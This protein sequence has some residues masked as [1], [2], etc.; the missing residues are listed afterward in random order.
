[1]AG[2]LSAC[3]NCLV[4]ICG[5][6]TVQAIAQTT[7]TVGTASS[8]SSLSGPTTST[9]STVRTERHTAIYSLAELNTAGLTGGS[10]LFGIAWDKTGVGT[11]SNLTI[12]VWLNHVSSAT[13]AANPSF[14]TETSAA[15]MV[16]ENA[17][18]TISATTGFIPFIFNTNFFTWNGADN[19]QV[20]TEIVKIAAY[21]NTSFSWRT[22][23]T[24]TNTAANNSGA[25][26]VDA[27]SRTG[28]RPQV[29]FDVATPGNDAALIGMP[30][31]VAA[32]PGTQQVEVILKNTGSAVLNTAA[33]TYTINGTPTTYNWAGNL[34]TGQ[35]EN[36]VLGSPNFAIGNYTIVATITSAN[37]G[38]DQSAGNNQV[39]KNVTI[40]NALTG[41]YTINKTQPTA[42]T[43]FNSFT[44]FAANLT[45]CGVVGDVVA[46]VVPGTGPYREQVIFKNIAG[47]GPASGLTIKGNGEV[48]TSDTAINQTGSNPARHIIRL[49]DM[50][51]FTIDSLKINMFTGST[52]FMGVHVFN[53]GSYITVK[54][55]T[56]DMGTA[57]STLLGALAATGSESSLLTGGNYTNI[58]FVNN[59]TVG[60]GYGAVM[61]G[62]AATPVA[63]SAITGNTFNGTSSNGIYVHTTNDL[64]IKNNTLN[65]TSAN[66][67]QLASTANVRSLVDG[68]IISGT[69]ATT[70]GTLSAIV[71]GGS[72]T[73]TNANRVVNNVIWKMNAPLGSVIGITGSGTGQYFFNTIILDDASATGARAI[74]FSEGGAT[75][76]A[77]VRSNIFYITRPAS[78]YNAA[79]GLTSTSVVT[80]AVLSSHNVFFTNGST[81][82]VAVRQGLT[83][84]NPPTNIYTDLP[85]WQTA[86]TQETG[87]FQTD[88]AF[89]PGT[90]KPTSGTIN[91]QG[92]SGAGILNDI[93][94]AMRTATPD[95]GA[96]EFTPAGNDAALTAF[97]Q[98]ALPH[99]AP[100]LAVQFELTNSGSSILTSATIN[101]TVNG[102]PQPVF[103]WTG[104]IAP[105]ASTNVTL[106]S[107]AIA[108]ATLYTF[109][110]LVTLPNGQPDANPA[111][112]SFTFNGFRAGFSGN[113]TIDGGNPASGTNYQS[114]QAIAAD[115][116][117]YGV[118]GPVNI[119][120]LNG[121]YTQQVVFT[122]IPGTSAT[123]AIYINGKGQELSFN[124]TSSAADHILKLSNVHYIQIDSLVIKSTNA[125]NGRGIYITDSSSH[126]IL[127]GNTVEVSKTV[128]S[129]TAFPIIASGANYLLNGTYSDSLHIE[130]NTVRGGYIGIQITGN[131]PQPGPIRN[132]VIKNN[133]VEDQY[134]Y[135]IQTSVVTN[136]LISGNDISRKTKTGSSGSF[137]GINLTYRSNN[138]LVEKNRIHDLD[139]PAMTLSHLAA[140]IQVEGTNIAPSTGS[141][142]NNLIYN[143]TNT[144]TQYGIT[145]ATWGAGS[146][147][148]YHNT[149][150][151][152]DEVFAGSATTTGINISAT[153]R[154][155]HSVHTI[156]NNVVY[157][158]RGGTGTKR[159]IDSPDEPAGSN[160]NV[161][162]FGTRTGVTQ[163]GRY[164]DSAYVDLASWRHTGNDSASVETNPVFINP[165]TGNFTPGSVAAN[166]IGTPVGVLT[167]ITGA[168][169]S[170]TTPDAGA[171]EF[172]GL[173]A[174]VYTFTGSGF[175]NVA[176]NWQNGQIPPSPLPANSEV[177]IDPADDCILNVPFSILPGGKLTVRPNK[178]FLIQG[179]LIRN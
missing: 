2:L 114:F 126:I 70:T 60:G 165:T 172:S 83:G 121:P 132:V 154:A 28:T 128:S 22:L 138:F 37:G 94:G 150:A 179:N 5:L 17:N 13:Y 157:I 141:I 73:G 118:C 159:L 134:L 161:V 155:T 91:D 39:T 104:N 115:L 46:T 42:G 8:T 87:S 158:S 111:N 34:Q 137:Y 175:W 143:L 177:I 97:I 15:V 119:N 66:G 49:T 11:G 81:S 19:I 148:I 100:S 18:A 35:Q 131:D 88:P 69:N 16:Y 105:G 113:L 44:D 176:G 122:T 95:P 72:G 116:A 54:N 90:A 173:A 40:C 23:A 50:Q 153:G 166:N 53:S 140:G 139:N 129:S 112:N 77:E 93:T 63:Q 1:M 167:D 3:R 27:M 61:Y 163:M 146:V 57:T 26:A 135:G 169:R 41:N 36:V 52:G 171:Y 145:D 43:N 102:A 24:A 106:G 103:N 9:T 4:L 55:C 124:P 31:P 12:R 133:T 45:S 38:P 82:Y 67:I 51:Y 149:I 32:M 65:F 123:N 170:T 47:L 64:L 99:C 101:W 127:K 156:R 21:T 162:Y 78:N 14:N 10:K 89:T 25:S 58:N 75:T 160:N 98:P 6:L 178:S 144:S 174:M 130:G 76:G 117:K 33:I 79:I 136:V 80:T 147:N 168:T 92:Y 107:T 62:L 151:L 96:Y 125:S 71:V 7:V 108:P 85:A 120:V 68:N 142:V 59:T 164:N 20:I 109:S 152:A 30:N 74:G 56:V 29:R 84:T 86:S 48:I 110:A